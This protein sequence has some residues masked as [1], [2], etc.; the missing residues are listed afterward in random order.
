MFRLFAG[1]F[2]FYHF[3]INVKRVILYY[4]ILYTAER[5]SAIY[6]IYHLEELL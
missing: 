6:Q 1:Y 4:G 3:K 2:S 5:Y